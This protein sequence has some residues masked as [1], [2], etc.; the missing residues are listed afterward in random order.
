MDAV[1]PGDKGFPSPPV[2]HTGGPGVPSAQNTGFHCPLW[3]V[4]SREW[5]RGAHQFW[6]KP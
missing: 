1:S 4:S 2:S 3:L 5:G 6:V